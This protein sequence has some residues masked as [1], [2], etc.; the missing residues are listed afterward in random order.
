MANALFLAHFPMTLRFKTTAWVTS[1]MH[2]A[3]R[4]V[5]LDARY[6]HGIL[7]AW[8]ALN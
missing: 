3:R 4:A 1:R 7:A 2:A 5:K 8:S 6:P